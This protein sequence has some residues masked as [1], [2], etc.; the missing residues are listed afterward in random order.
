MLFGAREPEMV[1]FEITKRGLKAKNNLYPFNSLESF[2]VRD[3]ETPHKLMI[4]SSRLFLPHI[5]MPLG[6]TDPEKVR[7]ILSRFLPE[8]PFEESLIDE[9]AERL[10][11]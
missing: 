9:L 8:V 3:H 6:D 1:N 11:F 4:E 7:A 5:V 2:A 10:G